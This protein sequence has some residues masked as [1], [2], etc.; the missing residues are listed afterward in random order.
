MVALML[1]L[2]CAASGCRGDS[3]VALWGAVGLLAFAR[4]LDNPRGW[5]WA[6]IAL[7]W[8]AVAVCAACTPA[9]AAGGAREAAVAH[10]ERS[11]FTTI[12]LGDDATTRCGGR[13]RK[14]WAFEG[15]RSN[16]WHPGIVCCR[17]AQGWRCW[18][19]LTNNK[20]TDTCDR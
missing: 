13:P 9:H 16:A 11:D 8:W 18:Y 3:D 12:I 2:A 14:G 7:V 20:E 1:A 5:W 19:R 4:A 17:P 10:L 6:T 15:W